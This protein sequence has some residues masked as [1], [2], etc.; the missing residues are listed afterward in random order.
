M[1]HLRWLVLCRAVKAWAFQTTTKDKRINQ[2]PLPQDDSRS[3]QVDT[4]SD[5]C[6]LHEHPVL[7]V[8][9]GD[10]THRPPSKLC[11]RVAFAAAFA[12]A[13]SVDGRAGEAPLIAPQRLILFSRAC[14]QQS[15][16]TPV[17]RVVHQKL[18][19]SAVG[20]E[21][22]IPN[23][24]TWEHRKW[25]RV[26]ASSDWSN[27]A[28]SSQTSPFPWGMSGQTRNV[29]HSAGCAKSAKQSGKPGGIL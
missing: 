7:W 28:K 23:A 21:H 8:E 25:R 11:V 3:K 29:I 12:A 20:R 22:L 15:Q 14:L 17:N 4:Q 1:G 5:A 10:G 13:R 16:G 26:F 6:C 19:K 24:Q 27:L 2:H 18:M 9:P